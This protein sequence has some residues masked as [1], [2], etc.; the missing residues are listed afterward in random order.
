MEEV[1]A[2]AGQT[3]RFNSFTNLLAQVE[4]R[5]LL[6]IGL[7]LGHMCCTWN[8][9]LILSAFPIMTFAEKKNTQVLTLYQESKSGRLYV[10]G[11]SF[12]KPIV[13]SIFVFCLAWALCLCYNLSAGAITGLSSA[14]GYLSVCVLGS[15]CVAQHLHTFQVY[16][17]TTPLGTTRLRSS[18]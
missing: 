7:S 1:S 2:Y 14:S 4:V 9:A 13:R 15:L 18:L 6:G 11:S 3:G 16:R 8:L 10:L 5:Q 17:G 12:H